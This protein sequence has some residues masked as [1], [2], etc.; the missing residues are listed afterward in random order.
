MIKS[1]Q[2][3]AVY[4]NVIGWMGSLDYLE[5]GKGYMINVSKAG[6]LTIPSSSTKSAFIV[7]D[8]LPKFQ[9]TAGNITMIAELNVPNAQSYNLYAYNEDGL[10][11]VA[12]PIKVSEKSLYFITI[13]GEPGGKI[14]FRID[15]KLNELTINE[16]FTFKENEQLGT[17][18]NPVKL[19]VLTSKVINI[20]ENVG[21]IVYPN[22]FRNVL[23]VKL[24]INNTEEVNII[25]YDIAG[26]AIFD[27]GKL[28]YPAGSHT[29]NLDK[30]LGGLSTGVYILKVISN[31]EAKSF[32]IVKH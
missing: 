10:C 26:N 18:S 19:S 23:N 13:N 9:T 7:D 25:L 14:M 20:N 31:S 16:Q 1:Q 5:P 22:P 12:V 29:I 27:T 11:G 15:D 21:C 17:I 24:N 32:K 4:D 28:T 8:G 30:S 2:K 6:K 3:F